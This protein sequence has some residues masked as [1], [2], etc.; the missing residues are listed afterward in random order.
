MDFFAAQDHARRA[1]R[2]LVGWFAAAVAAIIL[3]IYV[4]LAFL[5]GMDGPPGQPTRLWQPDLLLGT[6]VVVGGFIL[7][8]SLYKIIVL[9]SGGGKAVAES[10]GGRL[11]PRASTDA[12]ERRL[13]NVVDEMAI[14]AGMPAPPVYILDAEQGINAFAAGTRSTEGVVA[15]TRGTL[16]KLS[17]DELQGVIAH[18]FSHILNGDMRLNLRLIG[19][20]HGILLLTII[21]RILARGARGSDKGAAPMILMGLVLIVVGYIGVLFGKIIKAAVSR[22]REFLADAAAVQFTRNP[23]GIA[24]ALKRIAGFGSTLAHP[25]AEEA[26]HMFFGS[27]MALSAAFATHPPIEE[28]IRRID[29]SFDGGRETRAGTPAPQAATVPEGAA[30]FSAG[31]LADAVGTV[32]PE[33]VDH[34]RDLLSTLPA[35]L[36]DSAHRPGEAQAVVFALLLSDLRAIAAQ[37]LEAVRAAHG[38]PCA[39]RT[40]ELRDSVRAAGREARLPLLDLALPT[41]K[42]LGDEARQRTL[43]TVDALIRADGR[44]SLFEFAVRRLLGDGLRAARR[45]LS[46]PASPAA[47]REDIGLLLS[48]LARAGHADEQQVEAA[49]T[50]GAREAPLDGP[51]RIFAQADVRPERVDH[52]LDR[53]AGTAPPFRRR[54]VQACAATVLHDGRIE[55]AEMEILRALCEALE[56]P[57]PALPGVDRGAPPGQG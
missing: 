46:L 38:D 9:A 30:G 2:Q 51:W 16:E 49:F 25:R 13:I 55:A 27:G 32:R 42:E 54:L 1:S 10:L 44:V 19:V 37:Q 5:L 57:L 29:P 18:E 4:V 28:R 15:V 17:R 47:L 6:A 26:S 24:G 31:T 20:L 52:A 40:E 41:L 11:V 23:S 33:D 35:G 34:A 3:V 12:L 14:A 43:E 8:G 7:L 22:Q 36:V 56:C 39:R 48:L 50:A 45:G 53:L 21:G